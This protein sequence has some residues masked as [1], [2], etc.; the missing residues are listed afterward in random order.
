[1]IAAKPHTDVI[2]SVIM[3]FTVAFA[4]KLDSETIEQ[5][6]VEIS[7]SEN[8]TKVGADIK[9]MQQVADDLPRSDSMV[10]K[11][12]TII[13]VVREIIKNIEAELEGLKTC[14][15]HKILCSS[16]KKLLME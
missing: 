16:P 15:M 13:E 1:M 5:L 4:T 8:E 3:F 11:T 2:L 12:E 6:E 10:E 14:Q 9:R 7:V